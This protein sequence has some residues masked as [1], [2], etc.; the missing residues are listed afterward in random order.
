MEEYLD[1]LLSTSL[2]FPIA[3]GALGEGTETPRASVNLSIV[4]SYTLEGAGLS[5]ARVQ[6]DCY[7]RSF[8]ETLTASRAV[9]T[10][11]DRYCGGPIVGVLLE[12]VRNLTDDDAGLLHRLSLNFSVTYRE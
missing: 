9:R 6:I 4:P 7:G 11:L 8:G 10:L 5:K 3:W 1:N 2:S 12:T